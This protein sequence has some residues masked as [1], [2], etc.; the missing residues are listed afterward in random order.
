MSGK[1]NLAGFCSD[2]RQKPA[3][4]EF[5]IFALSGIG[6]V[7]GMLKYVVGEKEKVIY[8]RGISLRGIC[9]GSRAPRRI[10]GV[11]PKRKI[12]ANLLFPFLTAMKI[13]V[14][15]TVPMPVHPEDR[16]FLFVEFWR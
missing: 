7:L 2:A 3:G 13:G 12:S 8:Q 11:L 6:A 1:T 16:E 15:E 10:A 14:S 5:P 4:Q 9:R